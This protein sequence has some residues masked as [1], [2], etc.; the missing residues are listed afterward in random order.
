MKGK[1]THSTL[2]AQAKIQKLSDPEFSLRDIGNDLWISHNTVWRAIKELEHVWTTE[3]WKE[4]FDYNIGII[5]NWARKVA[6]AMENMNP[7][8]IREAKEMQAIVEV[9]FKQNQLIK[10]KPTDIKKLDMD[11]SSM[12]PEEIDQEIKNLIS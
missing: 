4:L 11:F 6:I 12:T 8:D 3:K 10:W 9:A 1:K 2:I 5:S 7:E